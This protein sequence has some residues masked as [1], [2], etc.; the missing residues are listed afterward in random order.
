MKT[1]S[2]DAIGNKRIDYGFHGDEKLRKKMGEE[3]FLF[4]S[5][6]PE[7]S[8]TLEIGFENGLVHK[9]VGTPKG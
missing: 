1:I 5:Q 2:V 6:E 4:G 3:L 9:L 8:G 7:T